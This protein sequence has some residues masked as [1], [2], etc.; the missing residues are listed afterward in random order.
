MCQKYFFHR[1]EIKAEVIEVDDKERQSGEK[2]GKYLLKQGKTKVEV[3]AYGKTY[4]HV[5]DLLKVN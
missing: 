4:L 1:K 3:L 2:Y 5:K